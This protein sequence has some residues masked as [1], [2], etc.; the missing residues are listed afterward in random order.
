MSTT[1]TPS[2][3]NHSA[4]A[5]RPAASPSVRREVLRPAGRAEQPRPPRAFVEPAERREPVQP[6]WLHQPVEFIE[7]GHPSDRI[8][9]IEPI[10]PG[11]TLPERE[12]VGPAIRLTRRGRGVVA[13]VAAAAILAVGVVAS[14]SAATPSASATT[15]EVHVVQP[16]E[17]L[18]ALAQAAGVDAPTRDVVDRIEEMNGLDTAMLEPGQEL[19]VPVAD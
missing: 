10:R 14:G 6:G 7:P 19:R 4:R 11:W 17:T 13:V 5:R 16:G 2:P 3:S 9:V 12:T 15:T 18:W 8:C 1:T